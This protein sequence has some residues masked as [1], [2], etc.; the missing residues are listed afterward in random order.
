M[1]SNDL[2]QKLKSESIWHR[3]VEK[4]E[5]I[6]TADAS[7]VSGVELGKLTKNLIA[8]T[9]EGEYLLLIVPGTAKIDLKKVSRL[10]EVGNISLVP[11]EQA[12]GISGYPPGGTPS[13]FHKVKLRVLMDQTLTGLD[14]LFCG[15]GSRDKILE[16][17]VRDVERL[18]NAI[19]AD[20]SKKS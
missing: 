3:F 17:K 1:D 18:D 5:T 14:T 15:G 11:F 6:H 9:N 2:E 12:E 20:I 13:V 4:P 16:L 19:V 8:K 10:L 7:Q